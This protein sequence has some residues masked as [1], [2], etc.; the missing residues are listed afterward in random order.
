M[1]LAGEY[2]HLF[3]FFLIIFLLI[4][5]K[6]GMICR[7]EEEDCGNIQVTPDQKLALKGSMRRKTANLQFPWTRMKPNFSRKNLKS[8]N[9]KEH[10]LNLFEIQLR[11]PPPK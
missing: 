4:D 6:P 7:R 5:R 2:I 10:T 3:N 8:Q 9:A 11:H 1:D